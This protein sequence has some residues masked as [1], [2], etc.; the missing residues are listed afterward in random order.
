MIFL[1]VIA[2]T[3]L[4]FFLPDSDTGLKKKVQR[5]TLLMG[6]TVSMEDED[7]YGGGRKRSRQRFVFLTYFE[8]QESSGRFEISAR[9]FRVEI[10]ISLIKHSSG[11]G[12]NRRN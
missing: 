9:N 10:K 11:E 6:Q 5:T 12:V 4:A 1:P 8:D 7:G 3:R 2:A